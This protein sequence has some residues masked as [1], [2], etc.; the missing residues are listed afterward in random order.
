M[1]EIKIIPIET[2]SQYEAVRDY[3]LKLHLDE[4]NGT[5]FRG[6]NKTYFG[7]EKYEISANMDKKRV[8]I[9]QENE[10]GEKINNLEKEL[11]NVVGGLNN[12]K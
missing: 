1:T 7:N 11:N 12:T 2:Y 3:L 10:D 4:K 8:I 5:L 6:R 9:I